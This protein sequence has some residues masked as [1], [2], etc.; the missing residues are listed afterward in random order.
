VDRDREF[1]LTPVGPSLIDAP[2]ENFFP[3][4]L[5]ASLILVQFASSSFS[6]HLPELVGEEE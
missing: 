6:H 2:E 1:Q 5:E 4:T 3:N